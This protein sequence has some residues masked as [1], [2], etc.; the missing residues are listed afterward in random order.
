MFTTIWLYITNISVFPR[1][2]TLHGPEA[3]SKWNE[4]LNKRT[5]INKMYQINAY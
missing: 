1:V 4:V 3:V 5:D 2:N